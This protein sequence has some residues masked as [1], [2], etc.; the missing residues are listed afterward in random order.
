MFPFGLLKAQNNQ[1]DFSIFEGVPK[2]NIG[3]KKGHVNNTF[4]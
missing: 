1:R 3:N 4:F 2:G